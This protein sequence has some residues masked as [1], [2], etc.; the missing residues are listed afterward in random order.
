[1]KQMYDGKIGS[2]NLLQKISNWIFKMSLC[3][4]RAIYYSIYPIDRF[5]VKNLSY[6]KKRT[7]TP[8]F[9]TLTRVVATLAPCVTTFDKPRN[10]KRFKSF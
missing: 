7:T 4:S 2:F 9:L 5:C 8:R 3:V 6:R 10:K 1:M